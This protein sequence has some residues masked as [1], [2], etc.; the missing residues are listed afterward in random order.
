MKLLTYGGKAGGA[1]PDD[2]AL[3]KAAKW[4][5]MCPT[6]MA[7]LPVYWR[8]RALFFMRAESMARETRHKLDEAEARRNGGR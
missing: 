1:A 2:Y 7:K 6:V 8:D 5:G 4:A 3:F